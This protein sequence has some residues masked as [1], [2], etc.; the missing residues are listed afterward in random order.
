MHSITTAQLADAAPANLIDVREPDEFA[1]GHVPGARNIP[2]STVP[3][4]VD[5]LRDL[6]DL[7]VICQAGVRSGRAVA[8]LEQQGVEATNVDGG[9]GAWI[10]E[11]RPVE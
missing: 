11:G 4:Y 8:F 10:A 2:L 7:H 5:E 1:S 3:N 6:D 9:T